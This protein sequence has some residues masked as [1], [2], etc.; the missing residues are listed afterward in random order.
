MKASIASELFGDL[1]AAVNIDR[2]EIQEVLGRGG[3][4]VV[5]AARDPVLGR[6][7]ALKLLAGSSSSPQRRGRM[8]REAQALAKVSHPNVVHVY[9]VGEHEEDVFLAMELVEGSSLKEWVQERRRSQ[10]ELQDVFLQAGEGLGA[11]HRAGLVHRDF[12]PSN[13]IVGNDGRVRVV[14]FGLAYGQGLIAESTDPVSASDSR[15]KLTKTGAVLGTPAYMA[16][17]QIRGE[18]ADARADQFSFCVSLFEALAGTRPYRFEELRAK[19]RELSVERWS[20]IPRPWRAALRKGL[21]IAPQDRWPDMDALLAALRRG[22]LW[23]GRAP[24]FGAAGLG[25]LAV[26]P[27]L[28]GD[29][30]PCEGLGSVPA[31]WNTAREAR[32]SAA[33]ERTGAPYALDVWRTAR[34]SVDEFSSAWSQTRNEVCTS[35]PS[36]PSIRCLQNA[37]VVLSSVLAEYEAVA[38]E[39]VASVHPLS[40]LLENPESC[41]DPEH[42]Y[43]SSLDPSRLD[44][45]AQASAQLAA[46]KASEAIASATR[47]IDDP[48][49]QNTDARAELLVLRGRARAML[50]ET[51]AALTD[52]ATGVAEAKSDV[53]GSR[54][55][56]ARLRVLLELEHVQTAQDDLRVVEALLPDPAPR[57]LQADL[58]ELRAQVSPD[59][60][61]DSRLADLETAWTLRVETGEPLALSRTR[62]AIANLLSESSEPAHRERARTLYEEELARRRQSLGPTHPLT[63]IAMFN[64]A[65]FIGDTSQDWAAALELLHAADAIES[66]TLPAN[67]PGRAR[68]RLKIGE[69]LIWLK[70]HDEAERMLDSAW[71]VLES[72]PEG[73]TDRT[74]ARTLLAFHT[75]ETGDYAASLEHHESLAALQPED[76]LLQQNIAFISVRLGNTETARAAV[77]KAR[78]LTLLQPFDDPTRRLLALYFRTIDAH[79]A[80]LEGRGEEALEIVREIEAA[81]S[82]Y[83]TPENMPGLAEQLSRLQPELDEIRSKL[84]PDDNPK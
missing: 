67:A 12:K 33:F 29:S 60:P 51:D 32:I 49:Y 40:T 72:L 80:Q 78:G 63:A 36:E 55:N 66:Q 26:A 21:A 1:A 41:L 27:S 46:N 17:E 25:L 84:D 50:A 20:A 23:W 48:S 70:R 13:V 45:I 47:V 11:A 77:A 54:T 79:V 64:L 6:T 74:A 22:R 75:M 82:E 19:S 38:A 14:D 5:Y 69:A 34:G 44:A 43:A 71:A 73:H 28:I 65:V 53:V 52:L 9:E 68:T 76:P 83:E 61:I 62:M 7:V 35:Q 18:S 10:D 15:E 42:A 56:I 8:V 57:S 30:D 58:Y 81:A 31:E 16:P 59:S 39:N 37:E 3:M 4:G 2:Y 24:W